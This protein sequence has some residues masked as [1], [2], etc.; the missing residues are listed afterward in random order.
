MGAN[1]YKKPVEL[2]LEKIGRKDPADLSENEFVKWG[3]ILE[4]VIAK[5]FENVTG[6]K[7]RRNNFV[8]YHPTIPYLSANLDREVVGEE[9]ILEVKTTNAYNWKEWRNNQTVAQ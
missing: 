1:K 9:A 7:V 5:E 3:K 4:P 2:W 8:L 6:K